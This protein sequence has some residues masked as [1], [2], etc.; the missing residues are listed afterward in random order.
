MPFG[1]G[2]PQ[3]SAKQGVDILATGNEFG[4]HHVS[5]AQLLGLIQQRPGQ[6]VQQP[7]QRLFQIIGRHLTEILGVIRLRGGIH[8]AAARLHKGHQALLSGKPGAAKKQQVLQKMRQPRIRQRFIMA[9]RIHPYTQPCPACP[10]LTEQTHR[11]A[12]LKRQTQRLQTE[13]DGAI[14]QFGH[15]GQRHRRTIKHAASTA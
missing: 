3:R 7:R 2:L 15:N 1:Q 4:M 9:A 5:L 11:Q 10:G 14:R 13:M 8:L 12:A 6:H